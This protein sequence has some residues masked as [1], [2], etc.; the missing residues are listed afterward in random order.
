MGGLPT[1]AA[2]C[3]KGSYAQIAYFAKSRER[4]KSNLEQGSLRRNAAS[5][6]RTS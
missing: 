6:E 3:T 2:T 4:R 5:P 1:F